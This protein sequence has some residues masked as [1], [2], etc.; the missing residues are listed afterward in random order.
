M[1]E[2]VVREQGPDYTRMFEQINKAKRE[3][4]KEEEPKVVTKK[5]TRP[6]KSSKKK[7]I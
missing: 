2:L 7:I 1:N 3:K 6:K 4:E 5:T